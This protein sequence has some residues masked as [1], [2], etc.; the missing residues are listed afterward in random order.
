MNVRM[1]KTVF[2]RSLQ[3]IMLIAVAAS[4]IFPASASFHTFQVN[5]LYS[6]ASGSVQ[7]IEL[8]E[9]FGANGQQFL[10][11]HTLNVTQGS[12]VRTF[13][14]PNDLPSDTTAGKHVLIAT[15]A[16]AALGIVTP[17][18]IVPAG[19]L[20]TNG[21]TVD[22]AGVDS[23]T[24]G[25]LP[26]DGVSSLNRNG[27]TGVNSPTNF[28]GQSGSIS[29]PPPPPPSEPSAVPTLGNGAIV[30]LCILVLVMTLRRRARDGR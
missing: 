28:A 30:A 5:E 8:L 15:S 3:V 12:T 1:R 13:T 21:A 17:D 20:F 4:G 18:Y 11:G 25:A 9:A 24:Y 10:G 26:V 27:T 23:V 7:F 14:F 22:Y 16:F 19:F 29:A 6:N 2:T